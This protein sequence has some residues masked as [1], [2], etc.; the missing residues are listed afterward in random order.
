VSGLNDAATWLD[1]TRRTNVPGFS[2]MAHNEL[3]PLCQDRS[4][5]PPCA[6]GNCDSVEIQKALDT[7][8]NSSGV[9]VKRLQALEVV[10][11]LVGDS[12][13]PL[14]TVEA[15]GNTGSKIRVNFPG[16][17][18]RTLHHIW[19]VNLV[20]IA[21]SDAN[22]GVDAIRSL[23]NRNASQWAKGTPED[24]VQDSHAVGVRVGY[25]GLGLNGCGPL[26]R[27]PLLDDSYIQNG[28]KAE[29][30]QLAKGAVRLAYALN[31]VLH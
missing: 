30:T 3:I 9:S 13:Q 7:L 26:P 22:G 20:E 12:H 24:W 31:A 16:D 29:Q 17:R 11:H 15:W 28:A 23:A 10:I 19:D 6:D 18:R 14:H 8:K 5:P 25:G 21:A 4:A 1:C 27:L 2:S